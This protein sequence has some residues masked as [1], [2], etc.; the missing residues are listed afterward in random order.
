MEWL[1]VIYKLNAEPTIIARFET[2]A[3]CETERASRD[4]PAQTRCFTKGNPP[5]DC[6]AAEGQA[7]GLAVGCVSRR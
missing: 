1:L 7:W 3:Q 5:P 4:A 2:Q 6:G